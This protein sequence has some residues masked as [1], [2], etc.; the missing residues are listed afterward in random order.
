MRYQI[1]K[2]TRTE[3]QVQVQ[4]TLDQELSDLLK[5]DPFA[6]LGTL[7]FEFRANASEALIVA[8]IRNF[9]IQARILARQVKPSRPEERDLAHLDGR[10]FDL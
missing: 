9:F 3:T 5:D 6:A 7:F 2:T 4:V 1:V 8:S 10:W